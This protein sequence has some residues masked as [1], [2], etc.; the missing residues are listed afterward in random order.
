MKP[1]D[2]AYVAHMQR[3]AEIATRLLGQAGADDLRAD[4]R[5]L[6]SVC[7][8]VQ[9]VGEAAS[10][11]SAEPRSE[12][13]EIPWARVVGMRHHLVHGYETIRVDVVVATVRN[14]LPSLIRSLRRALENAP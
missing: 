9:T 11:V 1:S 4:D 14:E 10:K 3:Y 6:L 8:A 12:H 13:P 2:R 5:T 7:Y